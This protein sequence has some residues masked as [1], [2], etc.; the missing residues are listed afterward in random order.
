MC[1]FRCFWV[2]FL[3]VFLFFIRDCMKKQILIVGIIVIFLTVGLSGC[4]EKS[5]T[6]SFDN[7]FENDNDLDNNDSPDLKLEYRWFLVGGGFLF[8]EKESKKTE[9]FN[10]LGNSL[11]G[12]GLKIEWE[13]ESKSQYHSSFSISLYKEGGELVKYIVMSSRSYDSGTEYVKDYL[14]GPGLYYYYI[15]AAG[16]SYKIRTYQPLAFP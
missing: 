8:G 10:L 16:C 14:I 4:T 7:T 3:Y 15:A 11:N 1:V 12:N 9:T 2:M 5:S 6:N 13:M